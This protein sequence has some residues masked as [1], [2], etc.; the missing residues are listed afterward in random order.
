MWSYMK[1]FFIT[2][3]FGSIYLAD[4]L[5]FI[6]FGYVTL[7]IGLVMFLLNVGEDNNNER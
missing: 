3:G 4:N 5:T 1:L 2:L 7:I 6:I